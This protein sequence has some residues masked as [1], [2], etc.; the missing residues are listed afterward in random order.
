MRFL[1]KSAC[2]ALA[3]AFCFSS[4]ARAGTERGEVW[5][6]K[7]GSGTVCVRLNNPGLIQEVCVTP[8]GVWTANQ[9]ANALRMGFVG[10]PGCTVIWPNGGRRNSFIITCVKANPQMSF[11]VAN[12]TIGP[13]LP[14]HATPAPCTGNT[15][16]EKPVSGFKLRAYVSN[17]P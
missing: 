1:T 2:A 12:S 15:S 14:I 11:T 6:R 9:L 8:S 5:V 4:L 10:I 7:F 17:C 3:L 13:F 16:A